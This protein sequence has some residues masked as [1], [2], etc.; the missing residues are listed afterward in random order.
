MAIEKPEYRVVR[1]EHGIEV[2]DYDEYWV[3]ECHV[4]NESDLS[5]ASSM[6][7]RRLFNYISGENSANQKIEMTSPVQQ[8]AAE[9][10]W[11]ISFVVPR[12]VSLGTIPAPKNS[13]ISIRKV[14]AG[15]YAALV[16]SGSWSDEKLE[17]KSQDLLSAVGKLGLVTDGPVCSA[18]Y[19]PPFMPAF[20]RRNEV[21]VR[22]KP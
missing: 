6:A 21:L 2:R 19:N 14:P 1:S 17:S 5:M 3:A 13:S 12:D 4:K 7:F 10:G 9:A 16:Y 15:R 11:L 8:T 22:L 18:R 20:L